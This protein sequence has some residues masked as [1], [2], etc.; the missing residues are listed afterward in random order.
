MDDSFEFEDIGVPLTY[1][2]HRGWNMS[3]VVGQFSGWAT[4]TFDDETQEVIVTTILLQRT[5]GDGTVAL[6][7]S[8]GLGDHLFSALEAAL[9]HKFAERRD[10]LIRIC[11]QDRKPDLGY[12]HSQREMI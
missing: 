9:L 11:T 10:A 6:S 2:A 8:I 7:S 1:D 12:G 3:C 5:G 4:F